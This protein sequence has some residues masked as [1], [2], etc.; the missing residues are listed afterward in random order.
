MEACKQLEEEIERLMQQEYLGLFVQILRTMQ[1]RF[2][3]GGNHHKSNKAIA[4]WLEKLKNFTRGP[5]LSNGI[6]AAF[7]VLEWKKCHFGRS[8]TF[9][10]LEL[11]GVQIPHQDPL[12]IS[13]E[14]HNQCYH[15]NRILI[16]NESSVDVLFYSTFLS[17]GLLREKL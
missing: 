8:I 6:F 4:K 16:Y 5:L 7:K 3:L 9:D 1:A 10:Y 15:F 2:Q 11:K 14:I 13:T 12:V 17:M